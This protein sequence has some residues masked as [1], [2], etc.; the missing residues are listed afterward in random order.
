MNPNKASGVTKSG[1]F[2]HYLYSVDYLKLVKDI[3]PNAELKHGIIFA[4]K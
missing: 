3:F 1:S 4:T 2:Q